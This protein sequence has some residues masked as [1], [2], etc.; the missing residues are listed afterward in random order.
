MLEAA[1]YAG[2]GHLGGSFSCVEILMAVQKVLKTNDEFILS[3]GHAALAL[4]SILFN[5]VDDF[6]QDGSYLT[7]H[8]S[9]LVPNIH[10]TTGSLGHGIGIAAGIALAKKLN[11]EKGQVYVLVGDGECM[12]GS[13]YEAVVFAVSHRLNNLTII[14]D[15]N[16]VMST[17]DMPE[18][19][20][21]G[22]IFSAIGCRWEYCNGHDLDAL[23][24][25]LQSP[26]E[27]PYRPKVIVAK[28]VKGK[29]VSFMEDKYEWHNGVPKGEQL[30]L[31][32]RELQ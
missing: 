25:C 11:A 1:V 27:S 3:K 4:Y 13:A 28:T 23:G 9:R 6:C 17:Q 19:I 2:R 7:E 5:D 8:P 24:I 21:I 15:D 32:R 20:D 10:L 26:I 29:G 14:L 12:E 16:G 22:H 31:A 30:E 18:L